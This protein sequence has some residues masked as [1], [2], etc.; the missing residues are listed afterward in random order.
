MINEALIVTEPMLWLT[1]IFIYGNPRQIYPVAL[2]LDKRW[3]VVLN[4]DDSRGKEE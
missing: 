2:I 1:H 3:K 4:I